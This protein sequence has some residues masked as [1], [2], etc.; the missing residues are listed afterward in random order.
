MDL[1]PLLD[2]ATVRE[3]Y[4]AVGWTPAALWRQAPS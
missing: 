3:L 2:L 4:G 1:P